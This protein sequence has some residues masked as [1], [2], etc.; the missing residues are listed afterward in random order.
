M[1]LLGHVVAATA[2][3]CL[4]QIYAAQDEDRLKQAVNQVQTHADLN[5]QLARSSE[6]LAA[7]EAIDRDQLW[8]GDPGFSAAASAAGARRSRS[9]DPRGV[10][11]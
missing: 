6:E 1:K 10:T 2:E 7:W 3:T 9:T 11:D 8:P 5:R 4:T